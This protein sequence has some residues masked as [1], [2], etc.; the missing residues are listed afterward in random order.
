MQV[1]S[2]ERPELEIKYN[3]E[4]SILKVQNHYMRAFRERKQVEKRTED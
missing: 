2:E 4:M 3:L 1:S